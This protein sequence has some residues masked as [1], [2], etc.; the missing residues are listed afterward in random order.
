MNL[1]V[2]TFYAFQQHSII[3]VLLSMQELMGYTQTWK[4]PQTLPF[5]PG[6]QVNFL[7][8]SEGVKPHCASEQPTQS[9]H[10]CMHHLEKQPQLNVFI[11]PS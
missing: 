9:S 3:C 2:L 6:M 10:A 7:S 4:V 8:G 5:S 1:T 11:L